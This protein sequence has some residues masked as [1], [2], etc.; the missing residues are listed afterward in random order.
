MAR[1]DGAG[2][3]LSVFRAFRENENVIRRFIRRYVSNRHDI[4]DITQETILRALQAEKSREIREP[5][6][7]LFGIAKNVVRKELQKKSQNLIVLIEDFDERK[8]EVSAASAEAGIDARQRLIVFWEAVAS[9]PPQCQRVFVLKKVYGYSHKEIASR[10][11]IS[12][13]TV[14][15]H[16]ASGL[17]RCSDHMAKR[18]SSDGPDGDFCD[19]KN[20][21]VI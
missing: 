11:N 14:E 1:D 6:A 19:G 18:L 13:S 2:S 8:D 9:L 10:L 20:T 16:A 4:E 21:T 17:R 12:V 5:R 3:G 15:K 7:F